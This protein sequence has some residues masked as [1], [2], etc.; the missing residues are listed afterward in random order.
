[1]YWFE[2]VSKRRKKL[3]RFRDPQSFF[4][5]LF[6]S[7][8]FTFFLCNTPASA[9]IPWNMKALFNFFFFFLFF[10]FFFYLLSKTLREGVASAILAALHLEKRK[11]RCYNSSFFFLSYSNEEKKGNCILDKF[12]VL[13]SFFFVLP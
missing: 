5:L 6:S 7:P 10:S 2:F 13:F 1:M 4:F 12:Y 8:F 3:C 11:V 9:H